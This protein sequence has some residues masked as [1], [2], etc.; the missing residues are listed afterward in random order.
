[1]YPSFEK[2]ETIP[3]QGK[4]GP[5]LPGDSRPCKGKSVCFG[6]M[7]LAGTST[8]MNGQQ[9]GEGIML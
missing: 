5:I 9:K 2:M 3:W 1:M 6:K 8:G 7:F 4:S